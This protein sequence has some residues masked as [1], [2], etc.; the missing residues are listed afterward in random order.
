ME[1][2]QIGSK[3]IIR[4]AKGE[5]IVTQLEKV[6]KQEN[7]KAGSIMGIGAA[8]RIEIGHFETGTKE[9]HSREF[10]GDLEITSLMGNVSQKDGESYLHIHINFA[11]EKLQ[12]YA[13]HLNSAVVS[14]TFECI[15]EEFDGEIDRKFNS[16]IGLDL[17]D[18]S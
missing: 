10:T 9:Y 3:H 18:L 15:I 12:A 13:G 7:I 1:T 6:C 17:M 14:A 16:E 5:E 2:K 4:V 11:D 8:G